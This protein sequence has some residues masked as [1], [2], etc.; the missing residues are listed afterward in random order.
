MRDDE[1]E[2]LAQ[3]G[4]GLQPVVGPAYHTSHFNIQQNLQNP[5]SEKL[6]TADLTRMNSLY[7]LKITRKNH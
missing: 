6:K 4:T 3:K 5:K 7:L 1:I 2:S